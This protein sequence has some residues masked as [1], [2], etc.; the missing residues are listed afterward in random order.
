MRSQLKNSTAT[1]TFTM[2]L[3]IASATLVAALAVS[4]AVQGPTPGQTHRYRA[5]AGDSLLSLVVC[6][7]I[8]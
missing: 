1:I 3:K 6:I 8:H 7:D 5:A 2:L 4:A